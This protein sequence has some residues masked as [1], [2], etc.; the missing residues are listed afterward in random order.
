MRVPQAN[1][2]QY[3]SMTYS[4]IY[5]LL[6]YPKSLRALMFTPLL[7]KKRAST[8]IKSPTKKLLFFFSVAGTSIETH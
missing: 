1:Y 8:M 2:T 7:G 3:H 4:E 6:N 5:T